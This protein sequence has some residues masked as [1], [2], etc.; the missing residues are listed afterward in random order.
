MYLRGIETFVNPP[1]NVILLS[2]L[3]YLR[4]I[5]TVDADVFL[6]HEPFVP[7]VPKRNRDSQQI[8]CYP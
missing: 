4:G 1:I 2:C 7:N 3:M 6:D 8:S 5:E